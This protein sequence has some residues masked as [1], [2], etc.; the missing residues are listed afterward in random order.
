[1]IYILQY[2]EHNIYPCQTTNE[3]LRLIQLKKYNKIILI[4]NIGSDLGGKNLSMKQEK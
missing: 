4:S 3:A 2:A 1:M